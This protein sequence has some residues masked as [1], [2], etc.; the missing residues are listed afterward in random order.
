MRDPN[1]QEQILRLLQATADAMGGEL[2]PA[3]L[4][5]LAHDLEPY[6]L[7]MIET[8]LA[9]CRAE[10][11]ARFTEAVLL[12][13]LRGADGRPGPNEAW[14]MVLRARDEDETVV[15]CQEMELGWWAAVDILRTG[16]KVGARLAFLD[17]YPPAVAEARIARRPARW[18]VSLGRDPELRRIA[19]E[20]AVAQG[21]LTQA[22]RLALAPPVETAS[23]FLLIDMGSSSGASQT[24]RLLLKLK[25]HQREAEQLARAAAAENAAQRQLQ[26]AA[27]EVR[28]AEMLR[29]AQEHPL[30]TQPLTT[31]PVPEATI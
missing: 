9:R 14:G 29:R 24:R 16:D 23:E 2:K 8:A 27:G 3:T 4:A 26:Y 13:R 25:A 21:L 20:K 11:G 7:P 5:L 17:V 15:W 1:E 12:D 6:T 22:Q 30:W 31:P 10:V 28:K 18:T 19:I